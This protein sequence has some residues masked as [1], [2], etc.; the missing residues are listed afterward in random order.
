MRLLI[1]GSGD[2]GVY[3]MKAQTG[4]KVWGTVIAKRAINTG[5]AVSGNTVIISHGD[6]NL[7]VNEL[8]MIAAIDGSQ[9]GDIKTMKWAQKGDQFGFS[10]PVIDGS[11]VYQ[12]EN[13]SR[14]KA[15]DL[16]K[17][18]LLW[19]QTLGTV[20][21]APLVLAD[22]KLYVG[23]ESGKFFIVRPSPITRRS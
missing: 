13:G 18:K 5:V 11:R 17:G 14:L 6:E 3:A 15:Y 10:S 1:S 7:D 20:Q 8:G 22:G 4:E 16:E 19:T 21:K 23:T 9:T 12:I 2:G